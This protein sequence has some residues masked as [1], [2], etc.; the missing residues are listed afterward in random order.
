[1]HFLTNPFFIYFPT[2]RLLQHSLSRNCFTLVKSNF[3]TSVSKCVVTYITLTVTRLS[4]NLIKQNYGIMKKLK[5]LVILKKKQFSRNNTLIQGRSI[6]PNKQAFFD[7]NNI[8]ICP[9]FKKKN[10]SKDEILL[11][12]RRWSQIVLSFCGSTF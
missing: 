10:L 3:V 11:E 7:F 8:F 1:M 2:F 5:V 9:D 6:T 4:N 12:I